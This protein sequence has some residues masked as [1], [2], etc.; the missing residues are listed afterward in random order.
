MC[1]CRHSY[2]ILAY[3]SLLL[4]ASLSAAKCSFLQSKLQ[5]SYSN[6][7]KKLPNTE[8]C[9][10]L[11]CSHIQ[12]TWPP[13]FPSNLPTPP[14]RNPPFNLL[15]YNFLFNTLT[16]SPNLS[17]I[18]Y[19]QNT[20]ASS[21]FPTLCIPLTRTT[22]WIL[23]SLDSRQATK[24][25]MPSLPYKR[26]VALQQPP[27]YPLILMD[28]S[29]GFQTANHQIFRS[30][31]QEL[32]ISGSANAL[33]TTY[34]TDR[35]YRKTW[36]ESVSES[37][38]LCRR[39][40]TNSVFFEVRKTRLQ[41]K[42]LHPLADISQWMPTSRY[43]AVVSQQY[44]Y[45]R[46]NRCVLHGPLL[47]KQIHQTPPEA[48]NVQLPAEARIRFKSLAGRAVKGSGP[49]YSPA[50]PLCSMTAKQLAALSLPADPSCRSTK[51]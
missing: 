49:S 12:L 42:T 28:V 21:F 3:Q 18:I 47:N 43:T 35:T 13:H 34:L 8:Q 24:L 20:W 22:M 5:T 25:R 15:L 10:L 36:K 31:L 41:H 7:H 40:T 14:V 19:F 4:S 2:K 48:A 16:L 6:P 1:E 9:C 33:F 38:S 45:V 32:W 26:D 51:S 44:K 30:T 50:C 46:P 17:C 27:S 39:H 37:W 29:A 23:T 11:L